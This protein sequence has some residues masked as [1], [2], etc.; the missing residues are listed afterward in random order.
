MS[1]IIHSFDKI[2]SKTMKKLVFIL[3]MCCTFAISAQTP[4]TL[5]TS[6]LGVP[7]RTYSIRIDTVVNA[8]I[9]PGNPGANTPWNFMGLHSLDSTHLNLENASSGILNNLFPGC[10]VTYHIDTNLDYNYY[11][12]GSAGL[13]H[14]GIVSDYLGNG[15]S[16]K[17]ILNTPDTIVALPGFYGDST[18]SISRG[19]TKSRCTYFLDTV[20][21]PFT[22]H[23][24]IDTI[25]IKHRQIHYAKFDAWGTM[26]TPS[27]TYNAL[28]QKNYVSKLDT[29]W[30]YLNCDAYGAPIDTNT[31]WHLLSVQS[32]TTLSYKWWMNGLGV[33]AMTMYMNG[34]TGNSVKRVEWARNVFLGVEENES[35]LTP[36][37]YPNPA[38]DFIKIN[39]T[40]QFT[41]AV[42]YDMLGKEISRI[43]IGK[44][45]EVSIPVS[46]LS[47]GLYFY[48]LIG[49]SGK[50]S[51]KF[52]VKH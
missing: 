25:R 22:L 8:A 28:R 4:I 36:G 21:P 24:P 38:N 10:N 12:S 50:T 2:L 51:G 5:G 30:I 52:E 11:K 17:L 46:K 18:I 34:L 13:V 19:D 47:N 27:N 43:A 35:L 6:D 15:D 20:V 7:V 41:E 3:L 16:I 39:N 29:I 37:V 31:G 48:N 9:I 40:S 23:I 49:K 33:P 26:T 14:W 32:D 42:I 44:L 1:F 45:N